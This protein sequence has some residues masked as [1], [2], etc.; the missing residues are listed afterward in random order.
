MNKLFFILLTTISANTIAA[1]QSCMEKYGS[2][3][4]AKVLWQNESTAL[5][6]RQLPQHAELANYYRDIQLSSINLM[7]LAVKL[8]LQQFPDEIDTNAK[9]NQWMDFSPELEAKLSKKS[10]DYAL[11][12]K[13]HKGLNN[14]HPNINDEEFREAFRGTVAQSNEF[15]NLLS[16][17]NFKVTQ[18]ESTKCT[19]A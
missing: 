11:A 6:V 8:S 9:L 16:D 19:K 4:D 17:F 18:I 15:Q 13:N 10:T 1:S 12:L 7:N 3:V 2:Y 14:A 5:I